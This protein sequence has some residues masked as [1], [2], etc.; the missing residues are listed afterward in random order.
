[1]EETISVSHLVIHQSHSVLMIRL[2]VLA[3]IILAVLIF[4]GFIFDTLMALIGETASGILS[5]PFFMLLFGFLVY[6]VIAYGLIL[7]WKSIY[8]E[9]YPDRL[10]IHG[11]KKR[12]VMKTQSIESVNLYQGAL[13]KRFNFGTIEI[14]FSMPTAT[15]KTNETLLNIPDPEYHFKTIEKM[16]IREKPGYSRE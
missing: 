3:L 2:I 11:I 14:D 8:F 1:M 12:L 4:I 16:V 10:V 7:Q 15:G 5:S 6:A 9:I 13:G